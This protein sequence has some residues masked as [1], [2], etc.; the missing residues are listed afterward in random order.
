MPCNAMHHCNA[1]SRSYDTIACTGWQC[2]PPH[3]LRERKSGNTISNWPSHARQNLSDTCHPCVCV[4][5]YICFAYIYIYIYINTF[6]IISSAYGGAM[7]SIIEIK[8]RKNEQN[9]WKVLLLHT[10]NRQYIPRA[11][12]T[13]HG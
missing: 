11:P 4:Y 3:A 6:L 1:P 8:N 2:R 9:P 10:T 5:I 7:V 13:F 12:G